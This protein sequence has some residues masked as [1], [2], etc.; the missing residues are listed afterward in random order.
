[1]NQAQALARAAWLERQ[2]ESTS[3]NAAR[4]SLEGWAADLRKVASQLH[5]FA[6]TRPLPDVF[7]QEGD[8]GEAILNVS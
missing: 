1:M 7:W 2:A 4:A 6:G 5:S 8:T 3:C